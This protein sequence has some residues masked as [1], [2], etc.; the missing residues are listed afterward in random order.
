ML[1][2]Q[3][4]SSTNSRRD[5]NGVANSCGQEEVLTS[6][7]KRDRNRMEILMDPMGI[8]KSKGEIQG[9]GRRSEEKGSRTDEKRARGEMYAGQ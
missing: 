5:M 8:G 7:A 3:T 9:K 2:G 6:T 4:A 1:G